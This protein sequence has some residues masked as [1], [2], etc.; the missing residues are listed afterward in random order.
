MDP[1]NL[2]EPDNRHRQR[3][4]LKREAMV[5]HSRA[6]RFVNPT[7]VESTRTVYGRLQEHIGRP[8]RIAELAGVA[9]KLTIAGYREYAHFEAPGVHELYVTGLRLAGLPEA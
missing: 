2:I 6:G 1:P 7:S 9:P 5:S 3:S 4:P 8:G